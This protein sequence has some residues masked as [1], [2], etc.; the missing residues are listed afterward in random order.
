MPPGRRHPGSQLAGL[1]AL[2]ADSR[3]GNLGWLFCGLVHPSTFLAEDEAGNM[4]FQPQGCPQP[5]LYYPHHK[6][7]QWSM[8]LD[9]RPP[10]LTQASLLTAHFGQVLYSACTSSSSR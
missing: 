6:N 2:S 4:V 9:A 10:G 8:N 3:P 7:Q 5:Q 1:A